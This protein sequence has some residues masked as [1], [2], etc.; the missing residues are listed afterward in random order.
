MSSAASQNSSTQVVILGAGVIGLTVAHVLSKDARYKIRVVARDMPEDLD[1]QAFASPWA[2][3]TTGFF[4]IGHEQDK[5]GDE[6]ALCMF[7]PAFGA[8]WSPMGTYNER[9]YK[10]EKTTYD[11]FWEMI[12]TGLAIASPSRVFYEE[13]TNLDELWYKTLVRDFRILGK[14]ELPASMKAGVGFQTVSVCPDAYLPWLKSELVARGVEFVR[15]R[16]VTLGEAAALAGPNGVL[17]NATGLGA[18]SLIGLEDKDV[19]PIRGQTIVI[20]N[21]KVHEFMCTDISTPCSELE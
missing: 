7:I 15:K 11:K 1:S 21:P 19:Y 13:G 5:C 8:N 14:D 3:S 18:R 17:V 16:V 10:W 6:P 9:I 12:P 4:S 20:D 2:V